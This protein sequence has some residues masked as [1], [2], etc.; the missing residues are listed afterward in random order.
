MEHLTFKFTGGRL[1]L[2][3]INTLRRRLT[4]YPHEL[5]A[6]YADLVAWGRQAGVLTAQQGQVLLR[7]AERQPREAQAVLRRAVA[8]REALYRIFARIAGK[9]APAPEDMAALNAVLAEAL[10][11]ARVVVKG[12]GF[13][14]AWAEEQDGLNRPLWPVVRSAAEVL[15]SREVAAVRKCAASDCAWVF[16]DQS[17]NRSRR[18]CD[19]KMCGNRA[20]ARRHYRQRK[21]SRFATR[22]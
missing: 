8:M 22:R 11:A 14:W 1:C 7:G 4:G 18:W 10:A 19:M 17:R 2:D 21:A 12:H 15:T 9:R 5:L 16:V 3:Y 6:T 20:K 13:T